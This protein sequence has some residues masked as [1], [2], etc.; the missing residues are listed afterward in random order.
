MDNKKN[1]LITSFTVSA[2]VAIV[3]ITFA[4]IFGELYKPF[5]N[6]LADTFSH[7]WIGKSII[8]IAIFY[9]LGFLEYFKSKGD[10]VPAGRQEDVM[11]IALKILFWITV[12]GVLAISGFYLYEYFLVH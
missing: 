3:F 1:K 5:K 10:A 11:I 8:A 12:V 9:A 2:I 7:H 4:T 6:Y